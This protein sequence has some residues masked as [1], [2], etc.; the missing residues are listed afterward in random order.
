[1]MFGAG[2]P[3]VVEE[4]TTGPPD[5]AGVSSARRADPRLLHQARDDVR[6]A[7]KELCDP[8]RRTVWREDGTLTTHHAVSLL[9]QLRE[10]VGNSGGRSGGIRRAA[11][12]P[13]A[14]EALDL[15][16]SVLA[17]AH[18]MAE[19]TGATLTEPGPE[20]AI[21]RAVAEAGGCTDL[22]V[23]W[24]IRNM[25]DGWA[26]SIKALLHPTRRI[27]LWGKSCPECWEV[28]VWRRDESDGEAKRTAALEIGMDENQ[29]GTLAA[30]EAR[31]LG[32]GAVW[33]RSRLLELAE[34]M[35]LA[36]PGVEGTA[37]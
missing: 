17:G 26:K 28:T 32:C 3:K 12:I 34:A 25:L 29:S 24:G 36:I 20:H 4:P 37:A 23:L 19:E 15:W 7:L 21:R 10:E 30:T 8:L 6:Y 13:V 18:L 27:P 16:N 33:P 11:P 2:D 31:C 5:P 22:E 1:M 35:G 14:V 9:K